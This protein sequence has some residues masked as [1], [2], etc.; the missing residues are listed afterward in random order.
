[1]FDRAYFKEL[2]PAYRSVGSFAKEP[3]LDTLIDT[4]ITEQALKELG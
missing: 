2:L 3:D 1:M 4:S